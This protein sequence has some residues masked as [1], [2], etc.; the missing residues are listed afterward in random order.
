MK[1]VNKTMNNGEIYNLALQFINLFED[2][3]TYM[4][5]AL[6]FA[7][8]KNKATLRAVAEDIENGRA[9][10]VRHYGSIQ[11]DGTFI[12]PEGDVEKANGEL[13]DLLSIEQEVKLYVCKIEELENIQFTSAQ[14]G[15]FMFMIEEE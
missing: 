4:P 9:E 13:N 8:Q 7:I 15:A 10:I 5:A 11:E 12:I 14:M 3:E 2:N 1:S 6:A